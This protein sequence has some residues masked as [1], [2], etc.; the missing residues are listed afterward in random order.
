[1]DADPHQIT[2]A[3]RRLVD[4]YRDR[5]LWFLRADY[6]PEGPEDMLRTLDY[7]ERHGDR[8]AYLRAA[9]IRKWLSRRSSASSAGS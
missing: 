2:D 1:M 6:Y 5:C 7:I 8:Q 9:E 3:V 4:D